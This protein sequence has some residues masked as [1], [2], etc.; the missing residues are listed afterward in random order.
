[1]SR[2]ARAGAF[3]GAAL[4]CAALAAGVAGG[5]RS[6]VAA[7]LGDLR[8]VL[9]AR[10]SLPAGRP[11]SAE[12]LA[13]ATELRRV[14]S[15]FVPLGALASPSQ[16]V[17][18]SPATP[19][20]AG[21]YVLSA[22]LEA[23]RTHDRDRGRRL[24]DGRRAV[25]ISVTAAGALAAGP[26]PAG[27]RVDVVVTTEPGP[28]GGPGRTYVAAEAVRLL[29]LRSGGEVPGAGVLPGSSAET[30]VATLALTRRQ[31]LRLI[32]AE[33]FARAVR[34]IAR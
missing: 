8:S 28:G 2:R 31:A 17:G 6:D 29:D 4:V 22:Q 27:S 16:A 21:A 30:W 13:R 12:R 32:Q 24:E 11:L 15:R 20:P 23:P 14:P 10:D 7:Q 1:M 33:S 34:L 9:V 26:S 18:L 3:A 19:I 25:E 5:Y